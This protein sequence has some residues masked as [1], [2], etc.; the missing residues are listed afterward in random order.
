MRQA[1]VRVFHL[2][3]L[4][5]FYNLSFTQIDT[6]IVEKDPILIKQKVYYTTTYLPSLS[7]NFISINYALSPLSSKSFEHPAYNDITLND[8]ASQKAINI[9]YTRQR[10][11]ILIGGGIGIRSTNTQLS[12]TS[13]SKERL[14]SVETQKIDT[15]SCF[16]EITPREGLQHI[17]ETE[18]N[19]TWRHI[20]KEESKTSTAS[21]VRS[22][23]LRIP[24]SIGYIHF[25]R[26][27]SLGVS[28]NVVT[29]ILINNYTQIKFYDS[30]LKQVSI[31]D[32]WFQSAFWEINPQVSLGYNFDIGIGIYANYN[33]QYML[34]AQDN[35]TDPNK[36]SRR[37]LGLSIKY[38]F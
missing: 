6:T 32:N 28:L 12:Q 14:D 26:H 5:S 1:F 9:S 10:K 23:H 4:L 27:L 7:K 11:G 15:I 22:T 18:I 21:H 24:L 29:N 30:D 20:T 38:F 37:A 2:F 13:F 8:V 31:N 33:W 35:F 25:K 3:I 16:V 17:C 19:S 36:N 34:T